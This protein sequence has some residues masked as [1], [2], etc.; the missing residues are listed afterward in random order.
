MKK[1]LSFM[2]VLAM[3][4]SMMCINVA[5]EN[6]VGRHNQTGTI[7]DGEASFNTAS[8]VPA[9]IQATINGKVAARY[10][11]DLDYTIETIT[12]YN[13]AV[14]NV[15]TLKYEGDMKYA[16]TGVT[17][18]NAATFV[19]NTPVTV[20]RFTVTNFSNA[21]VS[22]FASV[23]NN[24]TVDITTN[25][26]KSTD[27]GAWGRSNDFIGSTNTEATRIAD[28]I[29]AV[30]T[31]HG[32]NMGLYDAENNPNGVNPV[33]AYYIAEIV[34]S[35]WIGELWNVTGDANNTITIATI[36]F[37]V[38]PTSNTNVNQPVA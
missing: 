20:G 13:T 12:I 11:V 31:Q 33:A 1:F 9:K 7:E 32:A 21:S 24:S 37:R 10:A 25:I 35:D 36:T 3:I 38:Q 23:E 4:A 5:A 18:E 2:L 17:A 30:P 28:P 29:A 19:N 27:D 8:S 26:C 6:V 15:N 34:S 22:V 14:W 16:L